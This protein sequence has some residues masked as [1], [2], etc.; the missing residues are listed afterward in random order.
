[1]P[2]E[3]RRRIEHLAEVVG[4]G[5]DLFKPLK[6][7]SGGMKRKLEIIRSLMHRP[8][9]ALP[10][11]A[12]VRARSGQPARPVG[13]PARG[14]QRGRHD[15]LPDDPLPR[16]GRGGRP[17]LRHRPRQDRGHRRRPTS[18][19]ASCSTGRSC[20]TPPTGRRSRR[21]WWRSGSRPTGRGQRRCSGCPMRM[22]PPRQ[23]I[24]RIHTPLSVLRVHEP[25]LE[26]A[27]VELL[28]SP[29]EAVA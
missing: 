2:A 22:R 11:R 1:M 5:D 3:Y 25:S 23:L 19:S 27:Y 10:R 4:L 21:S 29:E 24:A 7:F 20:S 6:T 28:R 12:D 18:S 15:D 8:G 16:G 9:R 13:L 17:G 14:P 26:E